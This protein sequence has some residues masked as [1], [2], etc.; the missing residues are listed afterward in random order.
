MPDNNSKTTDESGFEIWLQRCPH[1]MRMA[2]I[3]VC[4]TAEM[5]QRW[6]EHRRVKYCAADVVAMAALV[7][8][9]E[10]ERREPECPDEI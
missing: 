4:D 5:C 7:L 8:A 10:A 1:E 9:R 6:M 3:D 2:L